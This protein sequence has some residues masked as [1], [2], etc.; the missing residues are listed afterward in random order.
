MKAQKCGCPTKNS[1]NGGLNIFKELAVAVSQ[2]IAG[3]TFGRGPV[4]PQMVQLPTHSPQPF[5]DFGHR[6]AAAQD[7][8][9]HSNQLRFCLK[10][11]IVMV[12]IVLLN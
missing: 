4:K 5:T 1:G 8:E 12:S 2:T 10:G 7:T 9:K 6:V 11:F 3:R